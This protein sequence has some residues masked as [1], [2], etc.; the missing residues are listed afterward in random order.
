M[1]PAGAADAGSAAAYDGIAASLL[2]TQVGAT[3]LRVFSQV[4]ST[5]DVAHALAAEGTPS[6]TAVLADMQS[7]GRGRLGR[8]WQS[9]PGQGVWVTVV[10]R[11][12][13]PSGVEVLS[14]RVGL[15]LA[16]ALEPFATSPI[17]LKWPND[18]Y[19]AH[20]KLGGILIEARWREARLD[21]V[22][23]GVGV[24]VRAAGVPGSA[25][26]RAGT[27][28]VEVLGRIIPAVRAAAAAPGP[29]T[30]GELAHF[31]ARDFA[32]GRRV[33]AP[34]EGIVAGIDAAGAIVIVGSRGAQAH[35]AGSLVFAEDA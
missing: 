15:A 2:A 22:A 17:R 14:L 19:T 28:R 34:G 25:A 24:N 33:V 21:W 12:Q 3:A 8:P 26:L 20:G 29:L 5:M 10:E 30:A 35:R 31:Q 18:L 13:D 1:V 9:E 4:P 7:A 27:S 23:I 6:G 16:E 11:P 32:A